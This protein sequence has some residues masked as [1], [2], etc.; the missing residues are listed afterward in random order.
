MLV[1]F[2]ANELSLLDRETLDLLRASGNLFEDEKSRAFK[3]AGIYSLTLDS[4]LQVSLHVTYSST[5]TLH[6]HALKSNRF[7]LF[8]NFIF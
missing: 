8:S 5:F 2:S 7:S 6:P 3:I 4:S 1:K